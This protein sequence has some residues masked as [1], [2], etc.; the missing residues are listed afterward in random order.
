VP[1]WLIVVLVGLGA[2]W[3]FVAAFSFV[4]AQLSKL[5]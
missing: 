4:L 3:L 2:L 5:F 1:R